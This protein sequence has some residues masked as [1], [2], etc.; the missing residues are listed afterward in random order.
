MAALSRS[1]VV[2]AD[3]LPADL[4]RKARAHSD[5][6]DNIVSEQLTT[7]HRRDVVRTEI[8]HSVRFVEPIAK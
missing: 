2:D 1:E 3:A 6:L 4:Q 8:T 5:D 7:R